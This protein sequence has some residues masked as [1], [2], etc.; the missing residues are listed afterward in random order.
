[1]ILAY[2]CYSVIIKRKAITKPWVIDEMI[3]KGGLEECRY[4]DDIITFFAGMNPYDLEHTV[5]DLNERLGIEILDMTDPQNPK[6][7][8]GFI[9]ASLF[10]GIGS[11]RGW[12]YG[13]GVVKPSGLMSYIPEDASP[14][15][16]LE[17]KLFKPYSVRDFGIFDC[18]HHLSI[19]RGLR[20]PL[21][22]R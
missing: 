2:P 5:Y 1:M 8:D 20:G 17:T 4:D 18:G 12:I 10:G 7:K 22:K 13:E 6:S 19:M 21:H 16:N 11:G 9:R 15:A 3:E 14:I